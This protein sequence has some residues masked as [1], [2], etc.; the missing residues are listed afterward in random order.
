MDIAMLIIASLA[1]VAGVVAAC[2]AIR[3]SRLTREALSKQDEQLEL[4]R[5]AASMIP[6]L[7]LVDVRYLK[8]SGF[9]I[10]TET[11]DE[12]ERYRQ[13]KPRGGMSRLDHLDI[14]GFDPFTEYE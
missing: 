2:S 10:V 11:L 13:E 9:P 12:A 6:E 5:S 8:T 4:A 1:L 3:S 7:E 14:S